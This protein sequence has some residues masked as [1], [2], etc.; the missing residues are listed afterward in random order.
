VD[1]ESD[2]ARGDDKPRNSAAEPAA[3]SEPDLPAEAKLPDGVSADPAG[4]ELRASESCGTL[5]RVRKDDLF[6][7]TLGLSERLTFSLFLSL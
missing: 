5:G 7:E 1:E 2:E 3:L 6:E 4:E